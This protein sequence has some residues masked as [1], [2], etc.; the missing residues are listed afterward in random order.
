[1]EA[2]LGEVVTLV[3]LLIAAV[4]AVFQAVKQELL[5]KT[6]Q[7]YTILA[8]VAVA[9]LAVYADRIVIK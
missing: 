2:N 4:V 9:L 5:N 6:A 1:M 3:G 8:G 7:V